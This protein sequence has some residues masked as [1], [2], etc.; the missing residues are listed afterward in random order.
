QFL[1]SGSHERK[2]PLTAI[3]GYAEGVADGAF[4]MD[5]AV[6]TIS[7][8]AARL[9]RLVRDLLDLARMNRTDFSIHREKVDL[10]TIARE[11]VQRYEAQARDFEVTL[12]AFAPAPSPAIRHPDRALQVTPHLVAEP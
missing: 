8:E 2:T 12:E 4:D 3:R 6:E 1:L 9:E 5:E 7:I 11:A 10:A